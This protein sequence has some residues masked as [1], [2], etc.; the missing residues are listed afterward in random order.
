MSGKIKI[1]IVGFGRSGGTL[2]A[3]PIEKLKNDFELVAVADPVREAQERA[4]QRFP[5]CKTYSDYKEML[6]NEKLDLVSIITR[7]DQHC[8]M[9]CHCLNAGVNVVVTKPWARFESEAVEMMKASKASGKLL[10]PWLPSRWGC[11]FIRIRDL[12]REGAIGKVFSIRR[13]QHAFGLRADWQTQTQYGGGILL[14][15]GPHLIEPPILAAGGKPKSVFGITRHLLNPG[16]AEDVFNSSILLDNGVWIHSEWSFAPHGLPN[17]FVQ[18]SKGCIIA[19]GKNLT[20]HAGEPG[21]PLPPTDHR[22]TAAPKIETREEKLEGE[23]FGDSKEVYKSLAK[24]VR[25]EVPFP[26]QTEEALLLTRVF[27][28]IKLSS[29]KNRI[30][31]L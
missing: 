31:N 22:V 3:D 29:E 8:E 27:D 11:D 12:I 17:W 28:A 25:G 20:I 16:D 18:G 6:K 10:L 5:H 15:W 24:A 19:N 2:H 1:A 9:A 7:S 4:S 21:E 23:V 30:V 26:V 14:N 13:S